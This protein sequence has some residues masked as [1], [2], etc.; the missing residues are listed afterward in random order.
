MYRNLCKLIEEEFFFEILTRDLTEMRNIV[1][2]AEV[3]KIAVVTRIGLCEAGYIWIKRLPG[4]CPQQLPNGGYQCAGGSHFCKDEDI[5]QYEEGGS[6]FNDPI[7]A[8]TQERIDRAVGHTRENADMI[9]C[10]YL[11]AL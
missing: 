11:K 9:F 1:V 7:N 2:E 4:E 5:H 3:K 8:Q 6:R 10:Q